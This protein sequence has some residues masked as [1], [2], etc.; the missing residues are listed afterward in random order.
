MNPTLD[1]SPCSN[2]VAAPPASVTPRHG[3]PHSLPER[4]N[5]AQL[6][7]AF[8]GRAR[9]DA[10]LGP[11]FTTMLAGRWDV[12]MPK[13]VDFWSSLVLGE[14]S[15]QGN[16]KATHQA[17]VGL[18][19]EHF[20]RW[21]A[22]FFETV[23]QHYEPAAAIQFIEPALRIAHSLQL[24]QFGWEFKVPEAQRALLEK[25]RPRRMEGSLES[26]QT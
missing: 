23:E 10:L 22:L 19:P 4:A 17:L 13:M 7:D 5:I 3:L 20:N 9:D 11:V 21:L 6:V 12:H 26:P 14:K 18:T 25:L 8:Y 2:P 24:S 16:L 1:A 15:Y